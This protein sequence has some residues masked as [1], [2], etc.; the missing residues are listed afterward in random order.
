L[1]IAWLTADAF[2]TQWT[3]KTSEKP[4]MLDRH[5]GKVPQTFL[6]MHPPGRHKILFVPC[7]ASVEITHHFF[8]SANPAFDLY[9]SRQV[10]Y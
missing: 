10:G 5:N 2:M 1:I 8:I 7:S 3:K 6:K 4:V 9:T